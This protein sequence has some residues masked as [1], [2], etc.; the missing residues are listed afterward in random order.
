M[1]K[2]I[3]ILCA[4]TALCFSAC[5]SEDLSSSDSSVQKVAYTLAVPD[6][7][8]ALAVASLMKNSAEIDGHK[9]TYKIVPADNIAT[10]IS[11]GSSDL[12]LMPTNASAKLFNKGIKLKLVSVNVFGVLYMVGKTPISSIADLKGK[13]VY[14]IGKGKTP[15]LMLKYFLTEA[16]VEYVE[17]DTA[18]SGKVALSYVSEATELVGK[19]VKG[20]AEYGVL[21]QP[22]AA[23][24]NV[25]AGT[26]N[27]LDFQAEW[28][29]INGDEGYPQ[30]GVV[31]NE[32]ASSDAS[33]ISALYSALSEN[34]EYIH[35]NPEQ[36][37]QL[38]AA[39]GSALT[40][41]FTAAVVEA[42]NIGCKKATEAKTALETY[43]N[44]IKFFDPT[45]IGGDLP[46]D[47]YYCNF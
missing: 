39:N 1:K 24:A 26:Q 23:N 33:F 41:D 44:A 43:F 45:F 38:L 5:A 29:N 35:E 19:L 28:E 46:S 32:A 3:A 4:V 6:G 17:S 9:M 47:G 42:C 10:E 20:A 40:F 16:N 34:Y 11:S 8:P 37:K 21:G 31:A 30:A 7:A 12:A 25:K 15:D 2:I 27:V 14:N 18:V 13:V 36:L 22:V